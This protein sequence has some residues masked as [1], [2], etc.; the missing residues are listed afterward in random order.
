MKTILSIGHRHYLLPDS[1]NVNTI[2]KALS[3]ARE[4]DRRW[5]ST[6]NRERYTLAPDAVDVSIKMIS[7]KDIL[8][9]KKPKQIAEHASPDAHN[10]FGS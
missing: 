8:D 2:L 5:D 4:L 6:S 9:P 7:P 10:T 1:A 3:A